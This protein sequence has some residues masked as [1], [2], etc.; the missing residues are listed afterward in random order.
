MKI[1]PVFTISCSE[2]R[3]LRTKA[4]AYEAEARHSGKSNL[5]GFGAAIRSLV[6]EW[7]CGKDLQR[8][9]GER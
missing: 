4:A 1:E 3:E 9:L 5:D 2:C 6:N 7:C 8:Q